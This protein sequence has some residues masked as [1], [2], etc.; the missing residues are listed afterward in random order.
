MTHL[1]RVR[2][3]FYPLAS[4]AV[5]LVACGASVAPAADTEVDAGPTALFRSYETADGASYFALSLSVGED[6]KSTRPL[7]M[8]IV[9]DTSA[10][11]AV[12]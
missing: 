1:S 6:A 5:C 12:V 4:L 8:A 9:F 3:K 7:D 11:Q 2:T 10:S